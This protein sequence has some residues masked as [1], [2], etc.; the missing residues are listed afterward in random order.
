MSSGVRSCVLSGLRS[1]GWQFCRIDCSLFAE[2]PVTY[3]S[4]EH[5]T[6][7]AFQA[8]LQGEGLAWH[9]SAASSE[10]SRWVNENVVRRFPMRY[11]KRAIKL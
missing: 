8:R 1:R 10:C 5:V 6:I 11:M 2:I 7:P 4:G 3:K 9:L